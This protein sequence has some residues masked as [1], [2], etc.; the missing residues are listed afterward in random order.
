MEDTKKTLARNKGIKDPLE[1]RILFAVN[2]IILT[3]ICIVFAYPII[4]VLSSSFSNPEAVKTGKVLLWP[5][6][7]GLQGYKAV[8]SH[9]SIMTGYRNTI[10]YTFFGTILNV[11]LTMMAAYPLSRKDFPFR[12][13][14][15][16]LFIFTM[17]FGGGL[18]PSYILMVQ[19][20][21]IDTV[22]SV[23][24]PGAVAAYYMVIVRTF[25]I[26]SIPNELLEAAMID[27][28]TDSQ[29][30]FR[31]LLPLSKAVLAVITLFY[32]V[33]HWNSYFNAMLY[34]NNDQLW[35]L[36]IIL[37]NILIANKVNLS[38]IHDPDLIAA[39]MGMEDLLKYALIIVSSAPIICMYPFVQKYFIKGVM[40]GSI[41]G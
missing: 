19:L 22:W 27:G 6:D 9:K 31:I 5:V 34:L 37:R 15:M 8:F 20:R 21:L 12:G 3:L 28:C 41:K 14:F 33:G 7:P 23:L 2:G 13:F 10:L 39:K 18:I 11:T 25:L 32:A 24:L 38:E 4:Y 40:I 30:F 35:P 26:N 16:F 1:D 29:Y 36:Q 17:F